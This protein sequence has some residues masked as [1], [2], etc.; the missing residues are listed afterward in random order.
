MDS[1]PRRGPP[2]GDPMLGFASGAVGR[3][4]PIVSAAQPAASG[5][6]RRASDLWCPSG[7]PGSIRHHDR[8]RRRLL[9]AAL[10]AA[11]ARLLVLSLRSGRPPRRRPVRQGAGHLRSCPDGCGGDLLPARSD[12]QLLDH[13]ASGPA[14]RALYPAVH[15]HRR[16]VRVDARGPATAHERRGGRRAREQPA[17]IRRARLRRGFVLCTIFADHIPGNIFETSPTGISA[18]PTLPRPSS[19]CRASLL[20]WPMAASFPAAEGSWSSSPCCVAPEALLR[21]YRPVARGDR[22]LR[23]GLAG[24]G[25]RRNS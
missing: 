25:A 8:P 7:A 15:R 1:S 16:V 5:E 11:V 24:P 12:L 18:F 23:R 22:H 17:A 10:G 4:T 20:P 6:R 21:A 3:H 9:P 2:P 14:A 13:A 19:S